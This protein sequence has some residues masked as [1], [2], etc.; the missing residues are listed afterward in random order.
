MLAKRLITNKWLYCYTTAL[1][2]TLLQRKLC[3]TTQSAFTQFMVRLVRRTQRQCENE[4]IN[5]TRKISLRSSK[6]TETA[7]KKTPKNQKNTRLAGWF[8]SVNEKAQ[9]RK[10]TSCH[11]WMPI[12]ACA[13]V[14]PPASTGQPLAS[15]GSAEDSYSS[16][17]SAPR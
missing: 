12:P 3:K 2:S 4:G 13:A 8:R 14:G 1:N 16:R 11:S 5:I 17:D 15:A 7:Y 9:K 10:T 6:E